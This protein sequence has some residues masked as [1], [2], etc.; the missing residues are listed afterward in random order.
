MARLDERPGFYV[1]FLALVEHPE[2][3][4]RRDAKRPK[5][6]GARGPLAPGPALFVWQAGGRPCGPPLG[7][8]TPPPPRRDAP[9]FL[10]ARAT[11]VGPTEGALTRGLAGVVGL[12]RGAA[13]FCGPSGPAKPTQ[14]RGPKAPAPCVVRAV[15]A[16]RPPRSRYD[17]PP[18]K[19]PIRHPFSAPAS[20]KH[21]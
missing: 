8:Q 10:R 13:A 18:S 5:K 19:R 14:G 2:G 21:N 16:R 11:A 6:R 15:R 7:R 3:G 1:A 20:H 4:R 17:F 12:R 9:T